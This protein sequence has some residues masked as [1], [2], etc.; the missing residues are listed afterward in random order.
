MWG[1]PMVVA[2]L[3]RTCPVTGLKVH[4][5][6]QRLIIANFTMALLSIIIGGIAAIFVGYSRASTFLLRDPDLYYMWLTAHGFNM[7]IFWIIWFEVALIYFV[8][9]VLLNAQIY[10]SKIG[11][12][13]FALML[14]GWLTVNTTVFTG[15]ASVLFTAYVPMAAHPLFYVGYILFAVGAG[16]ALILFFLTLYRARIEG[17][18]KGHLPLV[19]WG[20][21]IAAI[22]ALTVV[23]HGAIVLITTLAWRL[24]FIE[25]ID[26][27][28][29]RWFFWGLGHNAQYVNVTAMVAVWYALLALATGYVAARF[30][31][32]RYAR[33]AFAL[34][35]LFVVPG[36]GHHILVDPGF[37]IYLKQA[38]GSVGSHFLSVPSMLHALALLGGV[39]ATLR[40]A[41]HTGL[42]GWLAKIP[43]RN[44]G[45]AGLLLSMLLFGMGGVVAQPQ[46]TLQTN[47]LFHNTMWVPAHFHFVVVGGT[48]LAFMTLSYYIVPLLTLRRL[49][50]IRLATIQIYLM[51]IGILILALSMAVLGWLGAPRRTL[52]LPD[53]MRPEWVGPAT[54]LAIGVTIAIASGVLWV[55]LM[56]LT[57]LKGRRTTIPAELVSG[58]IEAIQV[59]EDLKPSKAGSLVI[60]IIFLVVV[61]LALFF[62]SFYKLASQVPFW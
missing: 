62:Y 6:T 45:V 19:T 52:V 55:A 54:A 57:V 30:V 5:P 14:V 59:R 38:S 51:F 8:S 9:T 41:G 23:F 18:Y 17:S 16:V 58:L 27:M 4:L 56:L 36:I 7:L 46:T 42:F 20:A 12:L 32:E 29:Y 26:V 10:S 28:F 40:A 25:S 31:N 15:N 43:W 22:I 50:S 11:W 39:E 34:Y 61:L 2:G 1:D 3:F 53:I 60:V 37:S 35:T 49:V 33:I 48:T 13:A 24:G 47:L 21:A 44:P